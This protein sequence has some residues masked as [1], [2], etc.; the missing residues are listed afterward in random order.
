[1]FK[2]NNIEKDFLPR[3]KEYYT[4]EELRTCSECGEVMEADKRFIG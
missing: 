4:S 2:L 1:M 3:F